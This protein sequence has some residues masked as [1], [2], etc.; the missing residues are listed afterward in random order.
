M[1]PSHYPNYETI[2]LDTL[3][4]KNSQLYAGVKD[5]DNNASDAIDAILN[6]LLGEQ[7][8]WPLYNP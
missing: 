7:M 4:T 8:Y 5:A 6:I 3:K 2:Y 1:G